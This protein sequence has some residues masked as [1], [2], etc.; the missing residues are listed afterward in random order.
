MIS[1]PAEKYKHTRGCSEICPQ[2]VLQAM[3]S[4]LLP[5]APAI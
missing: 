2:N 4:G 3:V 1:L 5:T